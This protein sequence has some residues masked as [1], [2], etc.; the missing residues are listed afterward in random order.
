MADIHLSLGFPWWYTMMCILVGIVFAWLMY[1]RFDFD[2]PWAGWARPFM[3]LL[4]ALSV[5]I[6]CFLLLSPVLKHVSYEEVKPTIVIGIDQSQSVGYALGKKQSEV[7][8]TVNALSDRL[9]GRYQVDIQSI[10]N[11][12]NNKLS[13]DFNK[14]STN[15]NQFFQN[16]NEGVEYQALGAVVMLSDGIF[17][18]GPSPLFESSRIKAPIYTVGVG[19]TIPARDLSIRNVIHNEIGFLGDI[20]KVQVDIQAFN[21]KGHSARINISQDGHAFQG[22]PIMINTD[23]FFQTIEFEIPLSKAGMSRYIVSVTQ[24]PGEAT[25]ANNSK[26][27]Y[28]DVLDSKLNIDIVASSPHPDISAIK[29]VIDNNKNYDLKIHYL[30]QPVKL[31]EKVDLLILYQVP[32]VNNFAS[33]FENLWKSI[34]HRPLPKLFVLG[35]QSNFSRFNQIQTTL[36]LIGNQGSLNDVYPLLR[37][38]FQAFAAK[39]EW[40]GIISGFPPLQTPFGTFVA[41][42]NAQVLMEQRIGRVETQYPLWLIGQEDKN[43]VGIIAGEGWWRWRLSESAKTGRTTTFDDI[44]GSTIRLLATREDKRKF[45]VRTNERVYEISDNISLT[46]ELYNDNYKLVNTPEVKLSLTDA[47]NKEYKFTLDRTDN[48]Y[49]LDIGQLPAGNYR[50]MARVL[51]QGKELTSGGDFTVKNNDKELFDLM[52][53]F[54]LLRQIS[55]DSGGRFISV[56]ELDKLAD[57]IKSNDAIK[58]IIRSDKRTDP[59]INL[60]WIFGLLAFLLSAEWALRRYLGRY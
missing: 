21:L 12:V 49:R 39:D 37:K 7:L 25:T 9:K 38:G 24:L 50:Y 28:I 27:F 48:A 51:F 40:Q 33:S 41:G 31:R 46:G 45:K 56:N 16:I 14:P 47:A 52:A 8:E 18:T 35:G 1:R 6:I 17:N 26:E 55:E 30:Y 29:S 57:M 58:P 54:G 34:Q 4:R 60:K 42:P 32:T 44:V 20:S 5:A 22:K 11:D 36:Q 53:D 43:R 13:N 10:G 59:L 15:L 23:D 2:H 19:D 3:F